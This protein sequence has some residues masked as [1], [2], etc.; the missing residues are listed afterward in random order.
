MTTLL[1][2]VT[3][4]VVLLVLLAGCAAHLSRPAA[5]PAALAAHRVL[6]AR[7][8]PLAA[9]AVTLAEG[10]LGAAGTAALLGRH[11]L[12]LTVV[13]AAAA[14]LF[15]CYALYTR[16]TLATGRGGPCGCSRA[17]VPLSGWVVGRAWAFALLALGGAL[18]ATGPGTPPEGAAE[19]TTAALA[20]LTFAALLWVLPTAM[21]QQAGPVKGGHQPWTS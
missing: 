6:P 19:A 1:G 18:V 20:A 3:T 10:L 4:G 16:H 12:G 8:V 2:A 11:R 5:L 14:A 9:G 17:E 7:A 21:A 13:L 15:T